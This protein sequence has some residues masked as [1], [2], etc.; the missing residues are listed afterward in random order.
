MDLLHQMFLGGTGEFARA[1][2]K[3]WPHVPRNCCS[4]ASQLRLDRS[5]WHSQDSGRLNDGETIHDTQLKCSS[6]G[7]RQQCCAFSQARPFRS[8]GNA[9]ALAV[10]HS[11]DVS[12]AF[13]MSVVLFCSL[14]ALLI[15]AASRLPS[16]LESLEHP[17]VP[18][19]GEVST[20]H[21]YGLALA[22][23]SRALKQ[24]GR[25]NPPNLPTENFP[26]V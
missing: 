25:Y 16:A 26:G 7:R 20:V 11:E 9:E 21:S 13:T 17:R 14:H 5:V 19:K 24:E 2:R 4:R 1:S 8:D 12:S 3:H 18:L 6:Q 10:V 15:M 22:G 23:K